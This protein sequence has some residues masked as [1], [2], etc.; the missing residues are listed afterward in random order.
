MK[1]IISLLS[2]AALVVMGSLITSC[3]KM[4]EAGSGHCVNPD[5]S[6]TYT[7]TLH[8][9]ASTK[10]VIGEGGAHTFKA[11]D[12]IA[13]IYSNGTNTVKATSDAL[14]GEGDIL[15]DNRSAR[16]TVTLTEPFAGSEITYVY[17]ASMVE[18]NGSISYDAFGTQDGTLTSLANNLD[19]CRA[20]GS[21]DGTGNLPTRTLVNQI[22]IGKFTLESGSTNITSSITGMTVSDGT[23][24]YSVTRSAAAGPIWVAMKVVEN[25][26]ITITAN[27][28][29][30]YYTNANTISGKTLSAGN[31]YPV[32]VTMQESNIVDLSKIYTNFTAQDG[33]TLTGTLSANV[34]ISIADGATVTLDGATI[35]GTDDSNY[36]WSGLNCLGDATIILAD[37]SENTVKG[38]DKHRAGIYFLANKT[39]TI[40]GSTGRLNVSSNGWAAGIGGSYGDDCGN[41]SIEGGIITATGSYQCPGIG[42]SSGCGTITITGGAITS[43]GG[44]EAPGIGARNCGKIT[45]TGGTVTATGGQYGAGIGCKKDGITDGIEIG[46]TA[47]VTATGGEKAAG[48]GSAYCVGRNGTCGNI[49]IGGT[50]TV[51]ATG[52]SKAAGIGSGYGFDSKSISSCGTIT[53]SNTVTSVTATKGA[54]ATNSIGKGEG[55]N[56]TCGTV[57][58]GS[59]EGAI[60]ESPYTYPTPAPTGAING[61][62]TVNPSGDQVYFSQGNLQAV[63]TTSS[64]PTSGW[65]W[66]FAEHQWDYIGGRSQSGS[67]TQT[68]NNYIN[69]NGSLS[70]NGTVDLFRWS[71]SATYFGIH[72]SDS[73]STYSGDFVEWGSNIGSGWRTLTKDEWNYLFRTR[74]DAASK[75][76]YATVGGTHG[77]IILPDDFTD[78]MKNNGSGAFAGSSTTTGWDA[79]VYTAGTNW[80]AMEDAG[81]VFLPAA[82][83][84]ENYNNIRYKEEQGFYK[85]S[86]SKDSEYTWMLFFADGGYF[87]IDTRERCDGHSVRLV[88]DAN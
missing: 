9:G 62:F 88:K 84:R 10:T 32:N 39:L 40:Q 29:T 77:I 43:T 57:T 71:T 24:N 28:G 69:G 25:K 11:G 16:F 56:S 65:T 85:A 5:G 27:T 55:S 73:Y 13:V 68:G 22:T 4:E 18:D 6:I 17:P 1:K 51:T 64:S 48:I 83:S 59:T 21:W 46:G 66:Q 86:T 35:N 80:D 2:M 49:S 7:T 61:L 74:T 60:T 67:E 30:V 38:F 52:G 3:N 63:G 45:I 36:W 53:I 44:E 31:I 72:N 50:A 70:A 20:S 19:Y 14:T 78:P 87:D 41:I 34:K 79:N 47:N 33:Q 12:Q 37:G 82:G 58:I 75:F 23:N 15:N 42:A 8:M 54:D 76:G 26:S 81:A